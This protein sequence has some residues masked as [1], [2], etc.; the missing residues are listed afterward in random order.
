MSRP[1]KRSFSLDGHRTSVSLEAPFWEAL[2]DVAR[3]EGV[4]VAALVQRIDRGRGKGRVDEAASTGDFGGLSGAIR[5]YVLAH[6]RD[7]ARAAR[8]PP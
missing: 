2:Q 7:Q 4:S 3:H 8:H 1:V 6:F 5:V